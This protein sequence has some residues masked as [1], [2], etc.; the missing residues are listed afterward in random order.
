MEIHYNA[1]KKKNEKKKP[2]M[3]L[4]KVFYGI[5]NKNKNKKKNK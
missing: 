1:N 4:N 2:K 5:N 3:T